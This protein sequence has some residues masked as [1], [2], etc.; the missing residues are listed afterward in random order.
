MLPF[1]IFNFQ[2]ANFG[3]ATTSN[4]ELWEQFV[5]LEKMLFSASS[6]S[7][8]PPPSGR[9]SVPP[10]AAAAGLLQM[11]MPGGSETPGKKPEIHDVS[12]ALALFER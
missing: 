10:Q 5:A 4:G 9:Q 2:R 11:G 1:A 12:V 8:P 6:A 3:A 7:A